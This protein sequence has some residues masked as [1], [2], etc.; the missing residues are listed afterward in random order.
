MEC[1]A[2]NGQ[3]EELVAMMLW[4]G[5]QWAFW[6]VALMWIVMIAF[7]GLVGWFVYYLVTAASR[8]R[9]Q[10]DNRPGAKRILDERLA[11][12]EIDTEEHRR[13]RDAMNSDDR[14][15]SHVGSAT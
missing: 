5:G 14:T 6:Q 11:H 10:N 15:G 3:I 2:H 8:N 4:N 12:G 1:E 9:Y 7:W 13:L